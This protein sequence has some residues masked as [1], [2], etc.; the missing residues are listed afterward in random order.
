[1]KG[2]VMNIFVTGVVSLTNVINWAL[3]FMASMPEVEEKI[4]EEIVKV[5]GPSVA[6]VIQLDDMEKYEL[7]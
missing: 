5:M 4:F 2:T 1:M 7:Y 6:R 3:A